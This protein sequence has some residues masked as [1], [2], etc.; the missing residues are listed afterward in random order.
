MCRSTVCLVVHTTTP[1]SRSTTRRCRL[2]RNRISTRVARRTSSS[3]PPAQLP[4][5]PRR[6]F[7]PSNRSR[8]RSRSLL[9]RKVRP[10]RAGRRWARSLLRRPPNG[11]PSR[12][13]TTSRRT[14]LRAPCLAL[15]PR[16]LRARRPTRSEKRA[17]RRSPER[18]ATRR[19]GTSRT[20]RRRPATRGSARL[21]SRRIRRCCRRTGSSSSSC[22]LLRPRRRHPQGDRS[23]LRQFEV[24]QVAELAGASHRVVLIAIVHQHVGLASLGRERL[25]LRHPLLEFVALVVVPEPL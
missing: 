18:T 6:T 14:V 3:G 7:P 17:S 20:G 11:S 2:T 22:L 21:T 10:G 9:G 8:V 15:H 23:S 24:Q 12:V 16:V 1:R 19:S 4:L 5:R 25:D 13:T